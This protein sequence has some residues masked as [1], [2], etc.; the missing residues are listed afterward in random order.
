MKTVRK[1]SI[2]S[3]EIGRLNRNIEKSVSGVFQGKRGATGEAIGF[4]KKRE[5]FLT[6]KPAGKKIP[7]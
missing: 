4:A 7:A 6:S 1:S 5:I 3:T 2:K